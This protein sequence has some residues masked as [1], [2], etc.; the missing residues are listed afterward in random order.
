METGMIMLKTF[1]QHEKLQ[2]IDRFNVEVEAKRKVEALGYEWRVVIGRKRD[3][4]IVDL[5]HCVYHYLRE[6]CWNYS[7]IGRYLL[8]NHATILHGCRKVEQLMI[9]DKGFRELYIKFTRI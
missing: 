8:K 1:V 3:R 2:V 6:H 5:R 9:H 4:D 7:R